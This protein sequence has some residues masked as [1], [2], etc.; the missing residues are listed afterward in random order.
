M[1][2]GMYTAASGMLVEVLKTDAIANNLANATTIGFKR[3]SVSVQSFPQMLLHRINDAGSSPGARAATPIG[4]LGTGAAI[5]E[6]SSD[7]T[8]GPL[9]FTGRSLDVALVGPGFLSVQLPNGQVA[10]TRAGSL[11]ISPDGM[12]STLD[13]HPV[14]GTQGPIPIH[15]GDVAIDSTG[16]VWVDGTAVD[17]LALVEFEA[18]HLLERIGDNLLMQ[19]EPSGEPVV[20]EFTT[21][22][23]EYLER[24]NTRVVTEMVALITS[25]R[26]Y[27]ANQKV[28]QVQDETLGRLINE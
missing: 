16:I 19:S 11:T 4:P 14:L 20:A 6:L 13:G 10:Y 27:E 22:N 18:P 3:Q 15:P 23:S 25:Q 1:L 26:A 9:Q 28:I 24:S 12:L 7:M 2:R 17:Q 21:V 8:Q 5:D